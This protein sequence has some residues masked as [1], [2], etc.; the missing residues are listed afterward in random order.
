VSGTLVLPEETF[1]CVVVG[2]ATYISAS[3]LRAYLYDQAE[4]A[5]GTSR[6]AAKTLRLVARL[7]GEMRDA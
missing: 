5:G 4:K 3:E 1:T 6:D 2:G 7:L